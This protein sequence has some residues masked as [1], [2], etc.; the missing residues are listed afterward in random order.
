MGQPIVVLAGGVGA[1]R[2]LDGLVR[3]VEPGRITVIGNTGDDLEL[4]GLSISPDL[5]TVCYTLAGVN[6]PDRGWGLAGETFHALES[7]GRF[8]D[9]TWFQLGDRDLATHIYRT[10]LIREGVSLSGATARI[11]AALGVGPRILPMTNEPV[12]TYL[13]TSAGRLDFQTYFVKRRAADEV[14]AVEFVGADQARPAP[15]VLEAIAEAGAII[16]APSNPIISIGP[17]LAVPGIRPALRA[18]QAPVVAVSPIVAGQA[19]K[20]PTGRMMRG[21]GMEV[22]ARRVAELYKDFLRAFV[23]DDLDRGLADAIGRM[24]IRVT[25]AQ[26]VMRDT[27]SKCELARAA[28]EA[29]RP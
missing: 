14:R 5:D 24:G 17:I 28:L 11:A 2:F 1:A 13:E 20:G 26:T 23:L 25:I 16:V 15:E 6:D 9:N 29:A 18:A 8:T 27:A 12:R 3:V 21:L 19:L 10:Q 4:H 22:S 7:L